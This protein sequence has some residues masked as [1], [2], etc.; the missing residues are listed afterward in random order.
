MANPKHKTP[1][2]KTGS[3]RSQWKLSLP[4]I[5]ECPHCRQPKMPHRACPNCGYYKDLE[6][7]KKEAKKAK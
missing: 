7:I 2:A 1:K 6:V 3:R 5:S 4:A